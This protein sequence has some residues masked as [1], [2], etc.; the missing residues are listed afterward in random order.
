MGKARA[1]A[2]TIALPTQIS[3]DNDDL[4]A[5]GNQSFSDQM[6]YGKGGDGNNGLR[7][8]D[9]SPVSLGLIIVCGQCK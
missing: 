3:A 4:S 6:S 8:N 9:F 1:A 2:V 5:Y 7:L